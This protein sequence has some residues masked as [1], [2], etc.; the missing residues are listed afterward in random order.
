MAQDTTPFLAA[1][2]DSRDW[3]LEA[4]GPLAALQ[5]DAGG[6]LPGIIAAPALLELVRKARIFG[7][8][9]SRRVEARSHGERI[10]AWV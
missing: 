8:R 4:E 6:Q 9:L 3:L 5:L 1:R 7:L 2:T 10:S